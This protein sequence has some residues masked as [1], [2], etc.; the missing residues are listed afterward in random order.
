MQFEH[1]GCP[2]LHLTFRALQL[3][4]ARPARYCRGALTLR[5]GWS[6]RPRVAFGIATF[7]M[8][9]EAGPEAGATEEDMTEMVLY[10]RHGGVH[11]G[12]V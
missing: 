4:Q 11:H 7:E 1:L 2:P 12:A 5:G 6:R 8:P 10:G 9:E 3:R